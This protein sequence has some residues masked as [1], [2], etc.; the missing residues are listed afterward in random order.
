MNTGFLL[1]TRRMPLDDAAR[2]RADVRA[3]VAAISASSRTPPS[4]MRNELA[5]ERRAIERPSDVLPR[6][7][8]RE[9]KNRA[10]LPRRSFR[11]ARYSRMRFFTF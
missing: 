9:A 11:T 10:L 1:P 5:A 2:E 3:P 7:E 4:E 8:P 6:R